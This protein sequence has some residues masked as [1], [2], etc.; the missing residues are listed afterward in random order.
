MKM[1]L[2]CS[3]N[4]MTRYRILNYKLIR[5][6]NILSIIFWWPRLLFKFCYFNEFL[7]KRVDICVQSLM[8]HSLYYSTSIFCFLK[9]F[10]SAQACLII[11]V[12]RARGKNIELYFQRGVTWIIMFLKI[13]MSFDREG[14]LYSWKK[15]S[16]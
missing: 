12:K 2:F 9:Y 11:F 10:L 13:Q 1:S 3:H 14:S 16:K 15:K 6:L 8:F 4:Y 5:I 7:A